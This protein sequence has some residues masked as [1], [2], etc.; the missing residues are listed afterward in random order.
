MFHS[1]KDSRRA[2]AAGRAGLRI[3]RR[4]SASRGD[5]V[6][7]VTVVLLE[8]GY[9]S[10]AIGPI[11]VF[12]SAGLLWN[13]LHGAAMEPRFRVRTASID[14]GTVTS[15]CSLGL[16]PQCSIHDIQ[17]T[18]IIIL[19]A[20]GWDV[21]DRIAQNTSLLPWLR[22]WHSRGA[23]IAGVCTGVAFLAECGLLDGRQATTHWAVADILRQRYPK[24]LWRPEQFVTED[25]RLF[26]SGG[27]Y[28]SID[29][30]LY[31]VEKFCG[32]E[33]ALQCA[34]SLLVS[35]PRSRQSGYSVLPLSPPHS[36]DKIRQAE[37][38]LQEHCSRDVSIEMLAGRIGMGPRNFI[39]RFKAATGRLPGA[40]I[41]MLR[42][43]AAKELLERGAASIQNVSSKIGYEDVAFFRR[44]FKRYTGM[45]PAE[46]RKR[47]AQ[48]SFDRGELVDGRSVA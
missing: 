22:K 43:S 18:D 42:V 47:F 10:T 19:P 20:S 39:R 48:M 6:L 5:A 27:I 31:L 21:M 24:V 23:Y 3:R 1:V 9:A 15:L 17:R 7:D 28:A 16:T 4:S 33:I 30:S 46:Y 11:E 2:D 26:C 40:Y 35:M 36:D 14:G 29:L 44:L 37:E 41:Q 12:H 25:G 45:T 38:Y 34:K 13:W 8:D 32:H